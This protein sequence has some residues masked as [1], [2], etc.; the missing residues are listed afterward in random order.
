MTK[1]T[2]PHAIDGLSL[3][4]VEDDWMVREL[5]VRVAQVF[6]AHVEAVEDG[7]RALTRLEQKRFDVVLSDMKMPR[8]D[9]FDVLRAA[10]RGSAP[11]GLVAVTGFAS[12]E[13]ERAIEALGA[14]LVRKPFSV[15]QLSEALTWS[16]QNR[17]GAGP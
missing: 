1:A 11:T 10:S 5:I 3:L 4:V 12:F 16:A 6:G 15:E 7:C 13:D 8:V 14:K 17:V 9:G 2:P